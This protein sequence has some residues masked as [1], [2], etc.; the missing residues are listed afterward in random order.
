MEMTLGSVFFYGG[1][2][3][4]VITTFLAILTGIILGR[5]RKSLRRKLEEEY[6][7]GSVVTEPI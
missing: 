5:S 4:L 2:V 3:G 1:I 7:K 6:G